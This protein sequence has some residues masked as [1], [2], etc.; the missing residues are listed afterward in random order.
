MAR[1]ACLP[2]EPIFARR[3]PVWKRGLD[4]LGAAAGLVALAPLLLVIAAAIAAV[5]PGPVF[6]G[7]RRVGRG[8]VE[9]TM[10][11]FRT[12][13]L[14]AD[15]RAHERAVSQEIATN[16][17][18]AKA[19]YSSEYIPLGRLLRKAS[20]DELPQLFN[21]LRG[22]MS[23]VGPRPEPVYAVR[24]YQPWHRRRL[25]VLPGM[26]GLWQV[27]GKNRTTFRR[28]LQLDLAY[29]ERH[30]LGLDLWILLKTPA[31]ILADV[32]GTPTR[33]PGPAT[34]IATT[35]IHDP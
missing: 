28:M 12:M 30:S 29:A 9:F 22:E 4:V 32:L 24:H 21:V 13:R 8:G 6:F 18:L 17:L 35:D 33:L 34:R 3:V 1:I 14:G 2:A 10:W 23:L 11:K 27:S 20:L 5:S 16:G 7:Q 25:D 19:D 15:T 31:V 26:T